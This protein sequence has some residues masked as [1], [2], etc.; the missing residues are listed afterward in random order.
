[1][2]VFAFGSKAQFLDS[3]TIAIHKRPGIDA[4]LES[5]NSFIHNGRAKI[6]G[7]R[8]GVIFQRKLRIGGG[9]SWLDAK[10]YERKPITNEYGLPDTVNNYLKFGYLCYYVDFVFHKTK[11]WQ[12]SVPIQV[13]TGFSHFEYTYNNQK[14]RSKNYFLLIYEPGITMQFKVFRWVGVGADVG[15]RFALKNNKFIGDRLNSPTYAF[16]LLVWFDQLFYVVAPKSKL[17]KK[18]G[19][20]YW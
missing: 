20:A 8:L 4:R 16:K 13:G 3:L 2:C 17:A 9:Y 11:R 7:V 6:S 18:Y 15:Y 5:R 12:L 19:P 10:V 1:M 14:V